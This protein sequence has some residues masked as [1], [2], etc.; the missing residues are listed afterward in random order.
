MKVL[1]LTTEERRNSRYIADLI[2]AWR[3][4]PLPPRDYIA[5]IYPDDWCA[6][7]GGSRPCNCNP[8]IKIKELASLGGQSSKAVR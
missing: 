3:L 5:T 4:K 7:L 8:D 6:L 1:L 2:A